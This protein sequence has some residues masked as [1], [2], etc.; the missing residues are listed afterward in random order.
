M[1][2]SVNNLKLCNFRCDTLHYSN[3][4]SDFGVTSA[5]VAFRFP[6]SNFFFGL[7]KEFV[8]ICINQA[9]VLQANSRYQSF[10]KCFI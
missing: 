5:F 8:I 10:D 3:V 9:V 4:S 2:K 7:I 1:V 6:I